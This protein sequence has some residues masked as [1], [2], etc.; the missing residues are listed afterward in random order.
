[1]PRG[2]DP[3]ARRLWRYLAPRL[4]RAKT[5]SP[6]DGVLLEQLVRAGSEL[7]VIQAKKAEFSAGSKSGIAGVLLPTK[8]GYL[9][10]NPLFTAETVLVDR[11]LKLAREFGLSPSARSRV[12]AIADDSGG[13]DAEDEALLG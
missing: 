2:L 12:F 8:T 10:L 11:I 5:L 3:A 7:A 1:M 4:V 6:S 13:A 9:M